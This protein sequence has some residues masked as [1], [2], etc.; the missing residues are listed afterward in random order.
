MFLTLLIL[1]LVGLGLT[2]LF[3]ALYF[4]TETE[5]FSKWNARWILFLWIWPLE[6]IGVIIYKIVTKVPQLFQI[7]L[8]SKNTVVLKSAEL[9]EAE[10]DVERLLNKD[11]N[12]VQ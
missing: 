2:T 4:Q 5:K 9:I 11:Q 6:I 3:S 8:P 1:Y 10:Q 12:E 7:A